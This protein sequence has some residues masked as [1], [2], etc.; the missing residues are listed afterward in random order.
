ML[1]IGVF[2][3]AKYSLFFWSSVLETSES[4][5]VLNKVF[6]FCTMFNVCSFS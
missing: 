3:K 5:M 4:L 6:S 1:N 2:G